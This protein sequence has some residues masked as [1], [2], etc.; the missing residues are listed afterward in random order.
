MLSISFTLLAFWRIG[1][2]SK[3]EI[4]LVKTTEIMLDSME[5]IHF[6]TVN[7]IIIQG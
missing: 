5:L 4:N 6:A 1:V 3:E 7:K 2:Y